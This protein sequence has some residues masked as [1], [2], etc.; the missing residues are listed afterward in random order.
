MANTLQAA[1]SAACTLTSWGVI[2][3]CY[4]HI[5]SCRS[6]GIPL[7]FPWSRSDS[8]M[9]AAFL[10]EQGLAAST[11]STYCGCLSSLHSALGYAYLRPPTLSRVIKGLSHM[12]RD[13]KTADKRVHV[14]PQQLAHLRDRVLASSPLAPATRAM[15]WLAFS[16]MWHGSL[17]VS[18][19][20]APSSRSFSR[21]STLRGRDIQVKALEGQPGK[22]YILITLR[23]FKHSTKPAVVELLPTGQPTCPVRAYRDVFGAGSPDPDSPLV[24]TA[25]GR[26]ISSRL[27]NSILTETFKDTLPPGQVIKNHSLRMGIPSLMGSRGYSESQISIQGRW[28]SDAYRSYCRE[29]R[30]LRIKDQLQIFE[31]LFNDS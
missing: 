10:G 7:T 29:G 14:T 9:F 27:L 26:Y 24:K 4:K 13:V 19:V 17:R 23:D 8:L 6:L 20:A 5:S 3:N 31:D 22:E 25:P 11:I 16:W 28:N 18:E 30:G 2:K 15:C 21:E 1:L 12:N